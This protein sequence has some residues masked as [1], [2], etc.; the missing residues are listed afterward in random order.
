MNK[1]KLE[2]LDTTYDPENKELNI[3]DGISQ[4]RKEGIKNGTIPDWFVTPSY[5]VFKSK[6][7]H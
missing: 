4:E 3:L 7:S 5:Q 1:N 6:C 2:E